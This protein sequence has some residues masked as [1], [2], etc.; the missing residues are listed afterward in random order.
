MAKISTLLIRSVLALTL[1]T[2]TAGCGEDTPDDGDP[3]PAA[4]E[5]VFASPEWVKTNIIDTDNNGASYVIVQ[6][7]YG[8]AGDDYNNGHIPGTIWVNSDEI[9]YD[10]FNARSAFPVDP[11]KPPC[12]DRS[13][14]EEEDAAKGLGVDDALPRNYWNWYPDEYLLPAIA[15]MGIDKDTTVVAYSPDPTMAARFVMTLRY[16]GVSE[17]YIVNGGYAAWVAAGYE[18]ETTPNERVP[19]A[20]FGLAQAASP[21]FVKDA[22]YVRQ[23]IAGDV[24]AAIAYVHTEG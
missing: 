10:C 1:A 7:A 11:G 24:D 22:A 4:P 15:N 5:G 6:F 16:A 21:A 3:P 13:T 9:E 23:I 17:T 8:P 19:V 12:Y 18:G 2:F 14:T 20:D